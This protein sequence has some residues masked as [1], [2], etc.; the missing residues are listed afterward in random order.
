MTYFGPCYTQPIAYVALPFGMLFECLDLGNVL[1]VWYSLTLERK[2]LLVSSQCSILTVCAEI[3]CSLLFPMQWSHLYIPT[4]PRFLTPMLD[5]PMPYLCGITRENM[6]YAVGDISDETIVVD[7][8]Q[9]VITTGPY[10]P[11]LPPIP[12]RRRFKLETALEQ[13]VGD[14]FWAARGLR[15]EQV[16]KVMNSKKPNARERLDDLLD[17]AEQ[18]WQMRSKGF[19]EAFNLACAPD[20]VSNLYDD[21]LN[22]SPSEGG[23]SKSSDEQSQYDAVQEAFLR[24]YVAALKGYRKFL[25]FGDRPTFHS[26]SF[27]K[28]QRED[29][30][31]FLQEF[32]QTQMFDA[33]ITKRLI[34]PGEPDCIFFDQSI[35]EKKNRSKLKINKT[36]TPFLQSTKSH[37][38][39]KTFH[40]V[41]P[42]VEGIASGIDSARRNSQTSA[43][44]YEYS[45]W[46][47]ALNPELFGLA[48]PIPRV[49]NAEFDHQSA[50]VAKIRSNYGSND[51]EE[52]RIWDLYA[53][54]SD[55][56][57]EVAVFTV[58][59]LLYSSAVGRAMESVEEK[60]K[61]LNLGL[62]VYA[63]PTPTK[64]PTSTPIA[65]SDSSQAKKE[66]A[67]E[68]VESVAMEVEES[69]QESS[70][71]L[72]CG[73]DMCCSLSDFPGYKD[74]LSK[75]TT[76]IKVDENE[77]AT[78]VD[79]AVEEEKKASEDTTAPPQ[80]KLSSTPAKRKFD[81]FDQ[82]ALFT[83]ELEEARATTVAELDLAFDILSMMGARL[84]YADPDVYKNLMMA[85][86]KC[87]DAERATELMEVVQEEGLVADSEMHAC[88]VNAFTAH[89]GH[90]PYLL[91]D[92]ATPRRHHRSLRQQAPSVVPSFLPKR[93][94]S[95]N[96]SSE[97]MRKD[98][99]DNVNL[100]LTIPTGGSYQ[101]D[102]ILSRGSSID[103]GDA[104]ETLDIPGVEISRSGSALS[105]GNQ[106]KD[107]VA[108]KK[109]RSR[110]KS[111]S[112]V[113]TDRL[114]V[115]DSV[116]THIALG[117]SLLNL[118]YPD[119]IIDTSSDSC[120]SCSKILSEDDIT[121][122][123]V[124]CAFKEYTTACPQCRHRFVP[125]FT[126]SCGS[127][128]FQGSQGIA[129]PLYCE[130]LSPW[131]LRKEIHNV[132]RHGDG[133][134]VMLQPKW[135]SMSD[136]NAT[137]WWNTIVWLK[138]YKLPISFLLQ[139]SFRNRLIL[140]APAE[141]F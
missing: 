2:V 30:R 86:G 125:K 54:E 20:S 50:L 56:S 88:F 67:S 105:T 66:G 97:Q 99:V 19:D 9:N 5:A 93:S 35:D 38:A 113:E 84:L 111:V 80:P 92:D 37:R 42:N 8:D 24:F 118:L 16:D 132:L 64:T 94:F 32:T 60:R 100:A 40:A 68:I 121:R 11:E 126:V 45:T 10:T 17:D 4:I 36:E 95:R 119:I 123:W 31:P 103:C 120:P 18:V 140:P 79:T 82:M 14:V 53:A 85:C 124:P 44:Q 78:V 69:E 22:S 106:L 91:Y 43:G 70:S 116:S 59:F 65:N 134:D 61:K 96:R 47:E 26:E 87:G 108:M 74:I 52:D 137:L 112:T 115:T 114:I 136:I 33:F 39:M 29:F 13:H 98:F 25:A 109:R 15:R 62:D 7:L 12:H 46:P 49:I 139:G 129:T 1:F 57:P 117:E 3:L 28:L 127:P 27:V 102:S 51:D 63:A 141:T 21:N 6:A 131:V 34:N 89:R 135:R 122:G 77:D 90:S 107:S 75:I 138:R 110:N 48:R 83:S 101:S 41:E 72:F 23:D 55:P 76:A 133:I 73:D 58:F 71:F 128:S 130:L 81:R 104:I